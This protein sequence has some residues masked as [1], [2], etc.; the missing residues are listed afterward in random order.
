[1]FFGLD[2][3]SFRSGSLF[4]QHSRPFIFSL[5]ELLCFRYCLIARSWI[6]LCESNFFFYAV[7]VEAVY[8][9]YNRSVICNETHL[10]FSFAVCFF[11]FSA[12]L[13]SLLCFVIFLLI[14]RFDFLAGITFIF[15]YLDLLCLVWSPP[16]TWTCWALEMWLIWLRNWTDLI[17]T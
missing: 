5:S 7:K 8:I 9:W 10:W 2:S 11:H 6:S 3:T 17:Q 15:T 4:P 14:I 12:I 13:H 16:A 1:M